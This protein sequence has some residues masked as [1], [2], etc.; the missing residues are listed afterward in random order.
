MDG[1]LAVREMKASYADRVI[2]WFP[3]DVERDRFLELSLSAGYKSCARRV[4]PEY[5]RAQ[6]EIGAA[7]VDF[8]RE[9]WFNGKQVLDGFYAVGRFHVE[10]DERALA[11][12][13]L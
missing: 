11:G 6:F 7:L 9:T 13:V 5:V 2:M 10:H 8:G 4:V 12:D 3:S 1:S